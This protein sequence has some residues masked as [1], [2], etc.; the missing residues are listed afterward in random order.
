MAA[1]Y[2]HGRTILRLPRALLRA[3]LAGL[4]GSWRLLRRGR[5]SPAGRGP[6]RVA[7]VEESMAPALLPGDWLLVD[8]SVRRWPRRGSVVV[9]RQPGTSMLVIKRLAA[10][11]GDTVLVGSEYVKLEGSAWLLGDGGGYSVDSRHYG[12]VPL[13]DLVARAWFRYWPPRRIGLIPRRHSSTVRARSTIS[14]WGKPRR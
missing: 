6:Y 9:I 11:P 1:G 8:P 5:R 4:R 2:R 14:S 12:P 13:E 3:L 7:V 10:G